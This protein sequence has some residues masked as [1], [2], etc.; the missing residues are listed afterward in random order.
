[1]VFITTC[2]LLILKLHRTL[3]RV[4]E[5]LLQR[6]RRDKA[7]RHGLDVI[8]LGGGAELLDAHGGDG[9]F[10]TGDES[11]GIE[12][13]ATHHA[14]PVGELCGGNVTECVGAD[15]YTVKHSMLFL[16]CTHRQK[17]ERHSIWKPHSLVQQTDYTAP[18]KDVLVRY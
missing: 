14:E 11:Q 17:A 7:E 8:E 2:D 3:P 5:P 1:M 12:T 15:K 4:H 18:Q 16:S 6:V 10:L 9:E 13:V